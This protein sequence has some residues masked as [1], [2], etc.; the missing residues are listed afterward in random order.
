MVNFNTNRT[1]SQLKTK[2]VDF[3]LP[4]PPGVVWAKQGA[5]ISSIPDSVL[6]QIQKNKSIGDTSSNV[7]KKS[8][9]D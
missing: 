6:K 9:S 2:K 4:T 5:L 8:Q 7:R 1:K 3:K